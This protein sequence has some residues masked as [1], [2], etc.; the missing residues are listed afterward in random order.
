V[1]LKSYRHSQVTSSSSSALAS[2]VARAEA[3]GAVDRSE[4]IA[5]LIP[6]A[7][8]TP[9]TGEAGSGAQLEKLM[10]PG[11]AR[12]QLLHENCP[13]FLSD[14]SPSQAGPRPETNQR[15]PLTQRGSNAAEPPWRSIGTNVLTGYEAQCEIGFLGLVGWPKSA[16]AHAPLRIR[17]SQQ[18]GLTASGRLMWGRPALRR[19]SDG[20]PVRRRRS[21]TRW[22]GKERGEFGAAAAGVRNMIGSACR[23]G[24]VSRD[25][26]RSRRGSGARPPRVGLRESVNGRSRP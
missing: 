15:P 18:N 5:G 26:G 6:L 16:T 25:L 21:P 7:L 19:A 1:P 11:A 4:K 17:S 13:P 3:L 12:L 8:V 20:S 22:G 9:E 23:I 24:G 2:F 14:T 10:R